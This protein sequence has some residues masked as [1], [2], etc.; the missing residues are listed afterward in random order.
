VNRGVSEKT[1]TP[2]KLTAGENLSS[3]TLRETVS[4]GRLITGLWEPLERD[5]GLL[6]RVSMNEICRS[7][8][9]KR[10]GKR[11]TRRGAKKKV[12]REPWVK[13]RKSTLNFQTRVL[14]CQ[15]SAHENE[16]DER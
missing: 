6:L 12:K 8:A 3:R 5:H 14:Q 11:S 1:D 7:D 15:C 10:K 2:G 4:G 16:V 9:I 13:G